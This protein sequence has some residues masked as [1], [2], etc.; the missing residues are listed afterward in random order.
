MGYLA[1]EIDRVLREKLLQM[2]PPVY[3]RIVADHI[4]IEFG[5]KPAV[6][7]MADSIEILGLA[8]DGNGLQALVVAVD[9][10]RLRADGKPYHITWSL[11]AVKMAPAEFDPHPHAEH[12]AAQLYKPVH[13]I[14]LV[15]IYAEKGLVKFFEAAIPLGGA[16]AVYRED[17]V[18]P[19][20][21]KPEPSQKI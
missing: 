13:S 17:I 15:E 9:G 3:S 20:L 2:I 1:F 16:L 19:P 8:D 18:P 7:P 12:R 4:T 10:H 5:T 6:I 11:D 14:A 21:Q